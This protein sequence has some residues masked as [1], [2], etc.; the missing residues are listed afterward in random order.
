MPVARYQPYLG[1]SF[2]RNEYAWLDAMSRTKTAETD[3]WPL[4]ECFRIRLFFFVAILTEVIQYALDIRLCFPKRRDAVV[5]SGYRCFAGIVGRQ[6]EGEVS[7]EKIQK[8]A[9][10]PDTPVDVLFG[11]K[12][13]PDIKGVC[14]GRHELHQA[15]RAFWRDG[16]VIKV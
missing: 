4:R 9:E 2:D 11:M 6:R 7:L 10:I 8:I 3:T 16:L 15:L 13:V 12:T 1:D 5:I 14:R